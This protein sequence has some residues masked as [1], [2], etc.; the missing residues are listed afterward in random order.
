MEQV[1]LS[2]SLTISCNPDEASLSFVT[3]LE[4]IFG[5]WCPVGDTGYVTALSIA[6]SERGDTGYV[7]AFSVSVSER[8]TP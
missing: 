1:T 6:V 7:T 2:L 8:E 3:Y 4:Q 5:L